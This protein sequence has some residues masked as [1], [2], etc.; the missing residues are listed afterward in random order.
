MDP[1]MYPEIAEGRAHAVD[2]D[3]PA[4]MHLHAC[5]YSATGYFGN[6]GSD[7]GLYIYC[8]LHV[9]IPPADH[10]RPRHTHQLRDSG[11]GHPLRGQQRAKLRVVLLEE[12][13][14]MTGQED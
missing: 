7:I 9:A 12:G 8:A 14:M 6:E 11:V 4:L 1:T 10:R 13:M 3:L 5:E 2:P